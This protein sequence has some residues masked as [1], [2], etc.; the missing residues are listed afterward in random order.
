MFNLSF[1]QSDVTLPPALVRPTSQLPQALV[2][3]PMSVIRQ[4]LR[5]AMKRC[6]TFGHR[7]IRILL[8]FRYNILILFYAVNHYVREHDISTC[9]YRNNNS[10]TKVVPTTAVSEIF[11]HRECCIA[12]IWTIF[13][14][15][16]LC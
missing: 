10:Q 7:S 11:H 5:H 12:R 8:P 1:S 6:C 9:T 3:M 14:R 16:P 2:T 4:S 13:T 15:A